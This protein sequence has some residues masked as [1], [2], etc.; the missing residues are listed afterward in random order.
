MKKIDWSFPR[1]VFIALLI[2]GCAGAYPLVKYGTSEV[3][4]AILIGALITT[5]NVL[6]GYAAIEYS[7]GKSMTSFIK[8]V[9][10]GMG[11]RMIAMGAVLVVLIRVFGFH[12]EPLVWSIVFFY[13]LFL[14]LEISFIQKKF[15]H[16]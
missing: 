3:R 9:L 12:A 15:A 7:Y 14:A 13:V 10:G 8:Y 11:I 4:E 5:L 1:Q 6:A 2:V 16:K